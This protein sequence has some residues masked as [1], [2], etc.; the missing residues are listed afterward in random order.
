[1]LVKKIGLMQGRLTNPRG[2]GI[3]FF[4]FENWKKEFI[5]GAKLK[6]SE[7]EWI[8]DYVDYKKNPLWTKKGREGIKKIIKK[9]GVGVNFI[10]ADYFVKYPLTDPSNA[11]IKQNITL[12]KSLISFAKDIGAKGVEIPVLDNASIKN[13]D[14]EKK[15]VDAIKKCLKTAEKEKILILLEIDFSPEKLRLLLKKIDH[16]LVRITYDSGN[17][18]GLGFDP[19][20]EILTYGQYIENFHIKDR[21]LGNGTK[22][23]GT[24]SADFEKIFKSLKKI[25]YKKRFILQVARGEDGK[26]VKEIKSQML[27]VSQFIKKYSL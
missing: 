10:C 20:K 4:P 16:L 19:E 23:L 1:M 3:Q 15:F 7:I 18:S 17:S 14:E 6:L 8:F 27:F 2:R 5:L 25:G 22:K 13:K 11:K 9:T 24:G 12:L 26:E 21:L